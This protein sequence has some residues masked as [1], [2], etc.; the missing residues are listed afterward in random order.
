MLADGRPIDRAD[1]L[2]QAARRPDALNLRMED[3]RVR[4][5][6]GTGIVTG[7]VR[8]ERHSGAAVATRYSALYVWRGGRWQMVH[9][10]WTR[11]TGT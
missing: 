8:Y 11:V 5:Y 9:V 3:V 7:T 4:I 1:F 2:S 10:Q 6:G